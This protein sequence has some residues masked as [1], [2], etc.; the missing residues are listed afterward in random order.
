MAASTV[1]AGLLGFFMQA[2]LS[3]SLMPADYGAAFTILTVLALIWLPANAVMLVMAKEASSDQA[4]GLSDRSVAVLWVWHRYLMRG[5]FLI[6]AIGILGAPSMAGFFHVAPVVLIPAALSVPFGLA[7]PALLGQL[8]GRQRFFNLSSLLIGQATLRLIA[9]VGLALPF[10]LVGV[11][12]GVAIGNILIYVAAVAAVH[13][14]SFRRGRLAPKQDVRSIAVILPSGVALAVLF[15]ADVL[16]VKHFF[17]VD[18]AGRYAAVAALGRAIFWGA[19]GIALVLFPKAVVHERRGSNGWLL[20]VASM[21][22][23]LVG[24]V[25]GWSIF[26]LEPKLL[27]TTFAGSAY[28]SASGYLPIYAVAM[29]LFGAASVLVA[30]GQARGNAAILAV[31]LPVTILEPTLI[32]TFHESLTQV[33]QVLSISMA[34]LFVGLVLLFVLE[35]YRQA[36]PGI[37]RTEA[38][39][40]A[41]E[42]APV[43]AP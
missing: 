37:A 33:V 20:V 38:A 3:H 2:L 36:H 34:L 7:V 25:M 35:E 10:G 21:A 41:N 9:A 39:L 4:G 12:A 29:T 17:G 6:A 19:S 14:S 43:S 28:A 22:L 24:G 11:F 15:S 18:D 13:P 40:L 26:S 23:C 1:T 31:L 32:I 30:T 42:L 27:L 16:L 8:Q 5:G